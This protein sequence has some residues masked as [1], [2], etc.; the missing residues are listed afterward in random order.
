MAYGVLFPNQGLNMHPLHWKHEVL[1]TGR[2]RKPPEITFDTPVNL[3]LNGSFLTRPSD[4]QICL[5]V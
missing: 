1:A 3:L 2:P 5:I 4:M